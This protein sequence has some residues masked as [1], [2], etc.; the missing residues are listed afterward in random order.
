MFNLVP[1]GNKY[2][3]RFAKFLEAAEDVARFAKL[4]EKF[5]FVIEY[6]DAMG[7]LRHYE[8]DFV[9]VTTDG[10]FRLLETKGLEDTNVIHKDRAARLWCENATR[11]TGN[12][13]VYLKVR[14][15]EFDKLTPNSVADLEALADQ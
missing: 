13:W 6:T 3:Q 5:A 10:V 14:E 15:H 2:E 9:A 7:S 4:P 12:E 8:P 11:L 1:C